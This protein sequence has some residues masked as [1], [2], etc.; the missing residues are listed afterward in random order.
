MEEGNVKVGGVR[1][2]LVYL[3]VGTST[4]ISFIFLR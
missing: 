3:L 4:I 1:E 2:S